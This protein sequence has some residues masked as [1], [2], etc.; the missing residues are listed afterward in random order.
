[1]R[2]FARFF[3]CFCLFLA[4]A[5]PTLPHFYES[6]YPR[7]LGPEVDLNIRY[8]FQDQLIAE[9][10]R[11]VLLGDS[12]LLDS[13]AQATFQQAIGLNTLEIAIPGSASAMWYLIFKNNI[14]NS[15]FRPRVVVIFFRDS[16]LTTADFRVN[17][18]YFTLL[19]EYAG[20]ND[21]LFVQR[22][23]IDPMNPLEKLAEMYLPLYGE[24]LN[25]RRT[26]DYWIKYK[27]PAVLARCDQTCTDTAT[28]RVFSQERIDQDEF[29]N[30]VAAGESTLYGLKNL[31]FDRQVNRSFLPEMVR[32][33]K[34]RDI[35]LIMVRQKTMRFS[36]PMSEPPALALYMLGLRSYLARNG[37]PL[38]DFSNDA[39]IT[40]NFFDDP[41]H[42]NKDG[43][44]AFTQ[45]AAEAL[46]PLIK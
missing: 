41:V 17:G 3:A 21:S 15:P 43:Q 28:D 16:E 40:A 39:R 7:P 29:E 25:I 36:S 35:R 4:V 30:E 2:F 23:Y 26:Q 44:T 32:L 1:M 31:L 13:V 14:I 19:D 33:A 34:E 46:L 9:H 27:I 18:K 42:M 24:R 12:A 10:D 6:R 5:W 11:V 38:V 37:I 8:N 20:A 45:M 22:A